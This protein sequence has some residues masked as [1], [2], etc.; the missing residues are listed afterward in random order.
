MKSYYKWVNIARGFGIILVVIGHA[1][2]DTLG[3]KDGSIS[4]LLYDI[5]YSFHMPL[6]FFISGFLAAKALSMVTLKDKTD[7]IVQRFKR[8]MV[9]YFCV[10]LLYIPLKLILASEVNAKINL[11]TLVSDFFVGYNPNYQLWTLYALFI[12]ATIIVIFVSKTNIYKWW[13]LFVAILMNLFWAISY[14]PINIINE[15]CF[16]F[17]FFVLGVI[18]RKQNQVAKISIPYLIVAIFAFVGGNFLYQ[19]YS[20]DIF[21]T[22]TG[23]SG[24][25]V[26]CEACKRI[27]NHKNIILNT[28]GKYG[29]DVYIMANIVQVLI[30]SIFLNRLHFPGIICFFMSVILGIALPILVS[31]YIVRRFKITKIMILG[32]YS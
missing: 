18:Y 27:E 5:I 25:I 28:V 29:M 24:I 21:K 1:L 7:Y 30:R 23:I 16:Q 11:Q 3:C 2:T 19:L 8:L 31:K 4:K 17:I 6:F 9:P 12:S 20:L 14:S 15:L 13:L 22:I 32:D 10:G 26:V